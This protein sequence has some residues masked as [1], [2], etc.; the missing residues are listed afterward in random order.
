MISD[1]YV[2]A[3]TA[4]YANT[5]QVVIFKDLIFCRWQLEK[6]IHDLRFTCIIPMNVSC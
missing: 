1:T 5:I 4:F 3:V 2:L 6:D